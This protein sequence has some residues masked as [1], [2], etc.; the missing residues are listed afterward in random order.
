MTDWNMTGCGSRRYYSQRS[1]HASGVQSTWRSKN[2]RPTTPAST[3]SR[4]HHPTQVSYIAPTQRGAKPDWS[5]HKRSSSWDRSA[6]DP[7][8]VSRNVQGAMNRANMLEVVHWLESSANTT[9][10]AQ[11]F[12][13]SA[14]ERAKMMKKTT[15]RNRDGDVIAL[16]AIATMVLKSKDFRK[17]ALVI[18]QSLYPDGEIK[19]RAWKYEALVLYNYIDSNSNL[20]MM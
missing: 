2:W 9:A 13:F 7:K 12:G 1:A 6:H 4:K 20:S 5:E 14:N 18:V 3:I 10:L 17:F 8:E 15:K 11:G 19:P 16:K